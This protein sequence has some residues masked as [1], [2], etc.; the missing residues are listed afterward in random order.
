MAAQDNTPPHDPTEPIHL[1]HDLHVSAEALRGAAE[2]AREATGR[3]PVL[4]GLVATAW[5]VADKLSWLANEID[6]T[7]I[8]RPREPA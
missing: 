1:L 5:L 3:D 2:G 4:T 7:H 8:R 6:A